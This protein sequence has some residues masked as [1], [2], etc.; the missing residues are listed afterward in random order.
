LLTVP[1]F[2]KHVESK[3]GVQKHRDGVEL[4]H[5]ALEVYNSAL[6]TTFQ[7]TGDIEDGTG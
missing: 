7:G 1:F 2:N 6:L 5:N 4:G 3:S